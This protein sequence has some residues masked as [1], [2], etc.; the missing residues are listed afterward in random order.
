MFV[1][2]KEWATDPII[3]WDSCIRQQARP[4]VVSVSEFTCCFGSIHASVTLTVSVSVC[5]KGQEAQPGYTNFTNVRPDAKHHISFMAWL[6]LRMV[7]IQMSLWNP[8]ISG[9]GFQS[10]SGKQTADMTWLGTS[11]LRLVGTYCRTGGK[12]KI[13]SIQSEWNFLNR[14]VWALPITKFHDDNS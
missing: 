11:L 14:T 8:E 10:V 12:Q 3:T 13:C 1:L 6:I 9:R 4:A 7:L 2:W 5:E